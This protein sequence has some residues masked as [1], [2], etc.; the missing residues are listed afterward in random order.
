MA[1]FAAI[2]GKGEEAG[3]LEGTP[4]SRCNDTGVADAVKTGESVKTD[5]FVIAGENEA[6]DDG[7]VVTGAGREKTHSF[8]REQI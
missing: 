4:K 7:T 5:F 6:M 1:L 8:E 3:L 2:G